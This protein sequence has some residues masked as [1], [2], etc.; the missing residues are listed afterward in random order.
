MFLWR[1]VFCIGILLSKQRT[2]KAL[3]R[4]APLL[5]AYGINRFSHDVAYIVI[6]LPEHSRTVSLE[7]S[8][9][10]FTRT[11]NTMPGVPGWTALLLT[12]LEG[13]ATVSLQ[14]SSISVSWFYFVNFLCDSAAEVTIC[15]PI[16]FSMWTI[17]NYTQQK[18]KHKKLIPCLVWK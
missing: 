6:F 9:Y 15:C 12:L 10:T 4:S 11:V 18:K 8:V 2:T 13:Q 16:Q 3:I 7:T 5:F 17:S 1:K 14:L